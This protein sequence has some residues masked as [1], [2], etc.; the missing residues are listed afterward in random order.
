MLERFVVASEVR[1]P[2]LCTNRPLVSKNLIDLYQ[3]R[4]G[5]T[6]LTGPS[7]PPGPP[8]RDGRDGLPGLPGVQGIKGEVGQGGDTGPPGQQGPRG[9][10]GDIGPIGQ[11]GDRGLPGGDGNVFGSSVFAAVKSSGNYVSSGRIT[12]DIVTIGEE[13]I[14]KSSGV[15]TAKVAGVYM[16]SYSGQAY[17]TTHSVIGIYLNEVR[18]LY[19]YDR[20]PSSGNLHS[21]IGYVWT[22]VL[23]VNDK[24]HLQIDSAQLYV[25][26]DQR[27]FFNGWLLNTV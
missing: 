25:D 19:I 18:D 22:F 6:G 4:Q 7:G 26:D 21:N 24:V 2:E 5:G 12:Y 27:F 13:L 20:E 16:F 1:D 23:Q 3:S 9:E 10:V 11:T 15:F 14:D 8:G 17:K